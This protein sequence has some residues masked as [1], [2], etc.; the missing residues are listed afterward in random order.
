MHFSSL[1]EISA[2][3]TPV[4]CLFAGVFN[5]KELPV[6]FCEN[7][8]AIMK[9]WPTVTSLSSESFAIA[10]CVADCDNASRGK[11]ASSSESL[12]RQHRAVDPGALRHPS[13]P[14]VQTTHVRS[15]CAT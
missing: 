13:T 4:E 5:A 1:R 14:V 3:K 11:L 7:A 9:P 6:S 2:G 12:A 15:Y 8:A 10:E